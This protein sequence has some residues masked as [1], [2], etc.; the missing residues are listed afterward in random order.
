[1]NE[2]N[3]CFGNKVKQIRLEKGLTQDSLAV[4]SGL[5]RSQLSKIESGQVDVQISTVQKLS[6]ALNVEIGEIGRASCRER[7]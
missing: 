4:M 5:E 2:I 3:V 7:V 6:T 1:M